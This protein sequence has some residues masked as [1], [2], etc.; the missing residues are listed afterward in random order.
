MMIKIDNSTK[1]QLGIVLKNTNKALSKVLDDLSSKELKQVTQ[2]KDIGTILNSLLK[3]SKENPSQ[4][5]ILLNLVKNNP[6]LKDL[7]DIQTTIKTLLKDLKQIKKPSLSQKQDEL[8]QEITK[9]N[10]IEVIKQNPSKQAKIPQKQT[11]IQSYKE[12]L[13]KELTKQH[14]DT[15]KTIAT[16]EQHTPQQNKTIQQTIEK[17]LPKISDPKEFKHT[18]IKN[19]LENSG[20][21]LESKLKEIKDPKI[22]FRSTLIKFSNQLSQ[23]K[24]P[25]IK[26]I[27]T[28]L[29]NLINQQELF[30]PTQEIKN[31]DIKPL[32]EITKKTQTILEKTDRIMQSSIDKDIAPKDPI[33]SK[34]THELFN[35]IKTLNTPKKLSFENH[36]KDVVSKDFKA[37]L[38]KIHNEVSNSSLPNKTEI[39]KHIDKLTM[40]IDYH[41]LLSHLSNSSAI[42]IP[43]SLDGVENGNITLK[44]SNDGRFFCDIELQ[45]KEYGELFLRLGLFETNQLH[46]NIK[47]Q[48]QKLREKFQENLTELRQQLFKAGLNP[49]DIRF[50]DT[51]AEKNY[52]DDSQEI[53]TGF[54]VKA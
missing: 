18:D 41:Q 19:K 35:K 45:L 21:F 44:N 12:Q 7:G 20:I 27:N 4:N 22:D 3:Q 40:Q 53:G 49:R 33:F 38:L 13:Q 24:I 16:K 1:K 39:L 51:Q 10:K 30:K 36:I 6:T 32:L 42:Y 5:K 54:E 17:F 11:D 46:I 50:L 2:N 28:E 14:T 8:K 9:E 26:T 15:I 52:N 34:P 48:S 47:T 23:S 37:T 29:K 25:Q 31:Q 43:Y